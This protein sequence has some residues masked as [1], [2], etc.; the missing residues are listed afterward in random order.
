MNQSRCMCGAQ[1]CK[2]KLY[3]PNSLV[4]HCMALMHPGH[5]CPVCRLVVRPGGGRRVDFDQQL[6]APVIGEV[7][8]DVSHWLDDECKDGN[9]SAIAAQQI[10]PICV[11]MFSRHCD[12]AINISPFRRQCQEVEILCK[13]IDCTVRME[14]TQSLH[15]TLQDE[16]V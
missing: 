13:W 1:E 16:R 5:V 8:A 9:I 7:H 11:N 14:A 15:Q 10:A 12:T 3:S 4:M 6:E 2:D